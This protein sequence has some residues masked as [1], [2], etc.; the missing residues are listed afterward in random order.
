M[1]DTYRSTVAA[2][3]LAVLLVAAG[4]GQLTGGA[5]GPEFQG[6]AGEYL[7]T[8]DTI[9]GW[10]ENVTREPNIDADRIESGRVIE[11]VNGSSEIQLS[12][13]VFP[14]AADAATFM[15]EQR[16]AYT[17]ND[18]GP[19]N[20]SLGDGAIEAEV[21]T[22]TFLDVR[23]SNVYVQVVGNVRPETAR[24]FARAQLRTVRES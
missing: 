17:E 8:A 10:E 3:A 4:C 11:L 7:L 19:V 13:L 22:G 15:S 6:D 1:T 16:A 12:V 14:A 21:P 20:R 2:L 23:E 5:S 18:L 24:Q 9:A